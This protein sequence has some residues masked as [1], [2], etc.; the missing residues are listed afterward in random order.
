MAVAKNLKANDLVTANVIL[1]FK[2]LAV[3]K[4]TSGGVNIDKDFHKIVQYYL[5]HYQNIVERL[6]SENG[7]EID[8]QSMPQNDTQT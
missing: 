7:Y 6:F 5:Q 2:V 8:K 4:A 3:V 1:D